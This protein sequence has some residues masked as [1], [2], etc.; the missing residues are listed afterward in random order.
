[1][2]SGRKHS[3]SVLER[4]RLDGRI[5]LVTGGAG[6]V[7]R[8]IS[9]GLAQAGATVVIASRDIAH[10]QSCAGELHSQGLSAE[11]DTCDFSSEES[12]GRLQER[13]RSRYGRLDVLINNAVARAG[14][15]R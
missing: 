14:T 11:A 5:A 10:A 9:A 15:A 3:L 7:G 12:I 8:H 13:L 2:D 1:V 4:F 6:V